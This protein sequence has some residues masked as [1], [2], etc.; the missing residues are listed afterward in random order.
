VERVVFIGGHL[1][2]K[3]KKEGMWVRGVDIKLPEFAPSQ[4]DEFLL[5]DCACLKPAGLPLAAR[6]AR[7]T[8]VPIGR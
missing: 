6:R 2:K 4:A 7:L 3:L 8:S 1:V 5:L